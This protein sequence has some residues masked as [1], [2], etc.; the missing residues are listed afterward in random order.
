M[1]YVVLLI[2]STIVCAWFKSTMRKP[3]IDRLLL[4]S[5]ISMLTRTGMWCWNDVEMITTMLTR[6][7]TRMLTTIG[8][9]CW[10]CDAFELPIDVDPHWWGWSA[11]R[12]AQHTMWL[13]RPIWFIYVAGDWKIFSKKILPKIFAMRLG[14]CDLKYIKGPPHAFHSGSVLVWPFF[15][16]WFFHIWITAHRCIINT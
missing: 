14:D 8:M 13:P 4:I 3:A 6:M 10:N 1:N 5:R 12:E 16:V 11:I 9:R 7:L 15:W 2:N